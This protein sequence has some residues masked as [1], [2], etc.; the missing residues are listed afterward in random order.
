MERIVGREDVVRALMDYI[1]AGEDGEDG[2]PPH[3][4]VYGD[5]Y[6]GKTLVVQSILEGLNLRHG[7]VS[8]RE[9]YSPRI[10][11]E[12][13][14]NSLTHTE[15]CPENGFLGRTRVDS[16][17]AF[18]LALTSA[19]DQDDMARDEA[20]AATAE[21]AAAAPKCRATFLVIDQAELLRNLSPTLPES[22]LLLQ[23]QVW[24]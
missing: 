12:H 9:A 21:A 17:S 20:K 15:P 19:I 3:L 13:L 11:F 5:A 10:L 2:L 24:M 1:R 23:E 14:L 18:Y 22:F 7:Y 16:P 4:V 8:A 6:T